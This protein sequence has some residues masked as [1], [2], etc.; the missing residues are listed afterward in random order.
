M[1]ILRGLLC[2]LSPFNKFNI[3]IQLKKKLRSFAKARL[4]LT[5]LIRPVKIDKEA[6]VSPIDHHLHTQAIFAKFQSLVTQLVV[7]FLLGCFLLGV[8]FKYPWPI[9]DFVSSATKHLE[10]DYAV[11]RTHWLFGN[12]AGFKPNINLSHFLGNFVLEIISVWNQLTSALTEMK[13]LIAFYI[14]TC[15]VLGFSVQ[16]AASND[17]LFFCSFGLFCV[18]SVF[19]WLYCMTLQ[20]LSTLIK[21]FRG[22]KYNI[23][24]K[25]DDAASFDVS[26]LYMGV[27]I[28]TLSIFLLPT[29]AIFYYY[30]FISIIISVMVLQL[31]MIVLQTVVSHFPY[32]LLAWSFSEPYSLPNSIKVVVKKVGR[33]EI[34]NQTVNRAAIFDNL[35]SEF[36]MLF[37]GKFMVSIMASILKGENLFHQMRGFLNILARET[38]EDLVGDQAEMT[39]GQF[40]RM[41]AQIIVN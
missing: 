33:I 22:K 26:E 1:L 27:L 39:E 37:E 34:I 23:I 9:I 24:R 12:P 16:M 35:I 3:V 40:L 8:F 19:A 2:F 6:D 38:P 25:R 4:Y 36:K 5:Q 18:Y 41:V 20:M 13:F 15:G 32:F 14:A 10:L 30:V 21:L 7:D 17:I 29:V 11:Q 31:V 28:V